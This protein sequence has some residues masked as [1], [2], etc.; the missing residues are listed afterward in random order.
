MAKRLSKEW[1]H[2]RK[3]GKRIENKKARQQSKKLKE[4]L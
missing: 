3:K 1:G 2:M 4:N